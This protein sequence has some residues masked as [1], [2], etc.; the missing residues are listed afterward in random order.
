MEENNYTAQQQSTVLSI[1][2]HIFTYSLENKLTQIDSY[3]LLKEILE[4][5]L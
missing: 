2:Y 5:Q 4:A 3:D 1:G